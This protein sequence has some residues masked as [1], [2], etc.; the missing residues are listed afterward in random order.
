MAPASI[1]QDVSSF[2][3]SERTSD[4]A[5]SW[6]GVSTKQATAPESLRIHW[7]CSADEVS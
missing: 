4:S 5:C 7:S 2:G 1:T 6:A 3:S